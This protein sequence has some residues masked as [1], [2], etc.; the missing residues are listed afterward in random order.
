[1]EAGD[2][3]MGAGAAMTI[4]AGL[5]IL[6]NLFQDPAERARAVPVPAVPTSA[7]PHPPVG[8]SLTAGTPAPWPGARPL[9]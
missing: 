6:D 8:R 7:T 4:P 2:R 5:S 1:M 9:R 3:R